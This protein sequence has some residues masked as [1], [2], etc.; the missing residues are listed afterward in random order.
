MI[1]FFYSYFNDAC[2]NTLNE[3]L[4]CG[5]GVLDCYG[6]RRTGGAP[7]QIETGPRTVEQMVNE[8]REVFSHV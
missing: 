4:L 6:M 8:Y 1:S 3:A 5:L 2:S 7:E